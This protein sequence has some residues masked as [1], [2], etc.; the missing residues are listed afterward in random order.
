MSKWGIIEP[1][2]GYWGMVYRITEL[3]PPY[4]YYIGA[5][6]FW[7]VTNGR[8]SKKRSEEL[9]KG[10]GKKPSREKKTKQS[11]W[12]TYCSSSTYVK[13]LVAEKGIEA[14]RWEIIELHKTKTDLILGE[15][16]RIIDSFCDPKCLNQWL[17]VTLYK[18]NI[19]CE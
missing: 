15:T 10:R 19:N 9:Y 2:E 17:K 16:L 3:D 14:F 7:S 1:P 12:K 6:A 5:K 13:A 11:D 4:R 18:K 8:I